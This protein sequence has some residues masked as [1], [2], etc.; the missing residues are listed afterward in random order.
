PAKPDPPYVVAAKQRNK[1]PF[2]AAPVLALLVPW[3]YLYYNSVQPPPAG[4]ND[5]L[6]IGQTVFQ[7]NCAGC[8]GPTGGGGTGPK[9]ADGEVLKTFKD[10]LAMVHWI[11]FGA[12]DGARPNGTY[13]DVNRPGGAHNTSTFS[14]T[15]PPW[16]ASLTPDEIA[17]VTMYVR[18]GLSGAKPDDPTEK[19]FNPTVFDTLGA[20]VTKVIALGPGGDPKLATVKP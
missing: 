12:A 14:A 19:A 20:I 8:H 17:A 16:R 3:A 6:V 10:P 1:V 11:A 5:P 4:A 15:M 18:E 13:G 2:W 7:G 9:L